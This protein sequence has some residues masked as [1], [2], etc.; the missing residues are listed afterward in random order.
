M[1]EPLDV[2]LLVRRD[3]LDASHPSSLLYIMAANICLNRIRARVRRAAPA[4][5]FELERIAAAGSHAARAVAATGAEG[6]PPALPL[7][8]DVKQSSVLLVK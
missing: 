3:R 6:P 7:H 1:N 8:M 5:D 2:D 4:E